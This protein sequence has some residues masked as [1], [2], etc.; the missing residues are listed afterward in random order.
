[1]KLKNV[2]RFIKQGFKPNVPDV[3]KKIQNAKSNNLKFTNTNTKKKPFVKIAVLSTCFIILFS[4]GIGITMN[5]SVK[6]KP[7][8]VDYKQLAEE[9]EQKK[10]KSEKLWEVN[11]SEVESYLKENF[12]EESILDID[13][14]IFCLMT[15]EDCTLPEE[16][17]RWYVSSYLADIK[18]TDAFEHF[19][20][21]TIAPYYVPEWFDEWFEE[22][23]S[24][25]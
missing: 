23:H 12:D 25:K 19:E 2:E 22:N 15:D 17:V 1:M 8:A 6:N 4:V 24:Q 5:N 9:N 10:L 16:L 13:S 7:P 11:T 3:W 20:L 18:D 14:K 21:D